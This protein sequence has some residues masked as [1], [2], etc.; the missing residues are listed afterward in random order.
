DPDPEL[1]CERVM[2]AA[3]EVR[4][5]LETCGFTPF[6][7]TTGGKGMHVVV[8]IKGTPKMSKAKR[9]GKIFLDYLRNDRMATAIAPWS[10]RARAGA[11]IATPVAWKEL[12]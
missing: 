3:K 12:R 7:K 5:A 9:G 1:S 10:P 6:V 8:A 4:D 2:D 11:T